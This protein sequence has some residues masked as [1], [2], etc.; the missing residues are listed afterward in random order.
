[1]F[2]H[3]ARGVPLVRS[4]RYRPRENKCPKLT[5]TFFCP[6]S[7]G[8]GSDDD[9]NDSDQCPDVPI[10]AQ[11]I[12]R[13][14]KNH[15]NRRI[16]YAPKTKWRNREARRNPGVFREAI[17]RIA[18]ESR[19]RRPRNLRRFSRESPSRN[20]HFIHDINA[21]LYIECQVARYEKLSCVH[22]VHVHNVQSDG[23]SSNRRRAS[24]RLH[25]VRYDDL[26]S[27]RN[28]SELAKLAKSKIIVH[29][30]M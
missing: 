5:Y 9:D 3:L 20:K 16:S 4:P 15:R 24:C 1:M 11:R 28:Y 30:A 25:I 12:K 22:C 23:L 13:K 14:K 21:T 27:A 10:W 17:L 26:L 8:G 29:V 6:S 19:T 7:D 18:L 2:Y